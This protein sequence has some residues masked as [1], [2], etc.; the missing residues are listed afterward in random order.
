M[1]NSMYAYHMC[2][3]QIYIYPFCFL[4]IK[5]EMLMILIYIDL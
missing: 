5:G 4:E 3:A 2:N 1:Y